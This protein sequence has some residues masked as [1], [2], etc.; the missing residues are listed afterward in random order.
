MKIAVLGT[1]MVG[2]AHAAK[3]SEL[4]HDVTVGT[5]DVDKALARTEPGRMTEAFGVW[6]K[7]HPA[8]KV[9][10]FAEAAK[11]AQLVIE[12]ISADAVID[13]LSAI[14]DQLDGKVLV[15]ITN[16][17]DFSQG[18]P[19]RLTVSNDDSMGETV[20]RTLPQTK[21]VKAFNTV[22]ARIQVDPKS[23]GSGDHHLFMAGND[24]AAKDET[25]KIAKAYG[26]Q[27]IL[28][29]GDIKSARGLEMVFPLWAEIYAKLGSAVFNYKIVSQEGI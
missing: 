29:L 23:L 14:K 9:A 24:Q 1:G 8:V 18:T 2:Q 7:Q 5:N 27:N 17:L 25:V 15:D 4:K 13:V 6:A 28:D 16:P 22:N 10:T 19:P 26:W 3:L 11:D 21:V 12:A 20:Q